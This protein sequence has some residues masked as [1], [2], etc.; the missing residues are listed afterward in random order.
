MQTRKPGQIHKYTGKEQLHK[1]RKKVT[2]K[3]TYRNNSSKFNFRHPVV[4]LVTKVLY[5][6]S[7]S[8]A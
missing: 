8:T 5:E 2:N 1:E 6:P 7:I 3:Q 4:I